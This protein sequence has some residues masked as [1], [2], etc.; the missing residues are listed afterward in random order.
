MA[1]QIYFKAPGEKAGPRR[2]MAA[3]MHLDEP[4]AAGYPVHHNLGR[5]FASPRQPPPEAASFLMAALAAWAADKLLPR[6]L[7]PDAWTRKIALHL[8]VSAA[9]MPLAPRLAGLLNFLTGDDWTLK[10]RELPPNPGL[11]SM[12]PCLAPPGS[13]A[14]LRRPRFPGRGHGPTGGGPPT[15]PGEPLR[16]RA[17]GRG[18]AGPGRGPGAHYGPERVHHLGLRVQFPEAPELSLRS[19]SVLYLA[20]G[21]AV[22]AAFGPETPLGHSRKRLGQPQPAPH[23]QPPG[24]LQHPHHPPLFSGAAG[25]GSGGRPAWPTPWSIPT[26]ASPRENCCRTAATGNC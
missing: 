12:A 11:G 26:R 23:P 2:G 9:W 16:L 4:G 8:P 1:A 21:L 6:P 14:V 20:L 22:A 7:A 19:R 3:V 10:M 25:R 15:G 18:P 13:G 24:G 17:T 5:L